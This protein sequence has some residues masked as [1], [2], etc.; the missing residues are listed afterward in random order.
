MSL[1]KL[2]LILF[3]IFSSLNAFA[4][5]Y[6]ESTSWN[7]TAMLGLTQKGWITTEVTMFVD[8]KAS[9]FVS[10]GDYI[11]FTDSDHDFKVKMI[12]KQKTSIDD[13]KNS[14]TILFSDVK[15]VSNFNSIISGFNN[16]NVYTC[17][18]GWSS[19]MEP[20]SYLTVNPC[21]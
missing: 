2:F 21:R 10:V 18:I 20:D 12:F 3:F 8:P 14:H 7:P 9:G 13:L 6:V 17:F 15:N 16:N 5:G 1:K 4:D 11:R 19:G